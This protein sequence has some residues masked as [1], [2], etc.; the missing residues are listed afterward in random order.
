MIKGLGVTDNDKLQDS[1][2]CALEPG[3]GAR[4]LV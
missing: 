3:A 2:S 4:G 1:S